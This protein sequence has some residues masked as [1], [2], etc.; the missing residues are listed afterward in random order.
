VGADVTSSRRTP[1]TVHDLPAPRWI[2]AAPGVRMRLLVEGIGTTLILYRIDPGTH[3]EAHRHPF[4]EL[5]VVLQGVGRMT[6]EGEEREL[7]AG[8]SYYIPPDCL[9][10]LE[11]SDGTEP[12][13]LIDVSAFLPSDLPQPAISQMTELTARV[14]RRKRRAPGR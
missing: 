3:F 1:S 5:G 4:G 8:E 11:V 7:R 10:G 14:V 6:V 13:V 12:M 9:H 2:E